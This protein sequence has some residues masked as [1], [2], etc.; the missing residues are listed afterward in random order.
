MG[1]HEETNLS[2]PSGIIHSYLIVLVRHKQ[3]QMCLQSNL[4]HYKQISTIF[5]KLILANFPL[6]HS[7]T[8][9]PMHSIK[10]SRK[11]ATAT[12]LLLWWKCLEFP[13]ILSYYEMPTC[14]HCFLTVL[15]L[16]LLYGGHCFLVWL[17]Q[18][19]YTVSHIASGFPHHVIM[20]P[21]TLLIV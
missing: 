4:K 13:K 1:V 2:S 7:L 15:A 17:P 12:P 21:N 3:A 18:R 20:F 16:I 6:P 11:L 8:H 19:S 5:L 9:S 14:M 10:H